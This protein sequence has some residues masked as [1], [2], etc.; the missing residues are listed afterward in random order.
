MRTGI[1]GGVGDV[2]EARVDSDHLDPG[3]R[4]TNLRL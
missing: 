4:E 2:T 1:G 3:P